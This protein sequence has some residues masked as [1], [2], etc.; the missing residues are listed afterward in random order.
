MES[1][2]SLK[3][4]GPGSSVPCRTPPGFEEKNRIRVRLDGSKPV[5][6]QL[7]TL[8][9]LY[10]CMHKRIVG[11]R[12]IKVEIFYRLELSF[13]SGNWGKSR[14][15]VSV[16]FGSRVQRIFMGDWS[17]HPCPVPVKVYHTHTDTQVVSCT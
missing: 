16:L 17:E 1:F 11:T 6:F 8:I 7:G 4:F 10:N 9:H 15:R 5:G 2:S 13:I 3:H 12:A 14:E